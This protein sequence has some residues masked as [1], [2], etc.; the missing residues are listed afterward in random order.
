MSEYRA[1]RLSK[2][3]WYSLQAT[4]GT[5][6]TA[7]ALNRNFGVAHYAVLRA[8]CLQYHNYKRGFGGRG[9][10][11]DMNCER[12]PI[13]GRIEGYDWCQIHRRACVTRKLPG[14]TVSSNHS[15]FCEA[16]PTCRGF[17]RHVRKLGATRSVGR[18]TLMNSF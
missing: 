15:C 7:T 1:R 13:M 17:I 16:N 14:S 10:S 5:F 4:G 2:A 3:W 12:M 6:Q 8:V 9:V 11:T 18:T